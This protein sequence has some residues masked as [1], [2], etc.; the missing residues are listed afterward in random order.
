[1]ETAPT[2]TYQ[3]T[4]SVGIEHLGVNP[5]HPEYSSTE[6]HD[7]HNPIHIMGESKQAMEEWMT[8]IVPKVMPQV[9]TLLQQVTDMKH[10]A[11]HPDGRI[12]DDVMKTELGT[13][14]HQ[15]IA[16]EKQ[17]QKAYDRLRSCKVLIHDVLE[18]NPLYTKYLSSISK[19]PIFGRV[20]TKNSTGT[21]ST[22]EQH[23]VLDQYYQQDFLHQY[24]TAMMEYQTVSDQCQHILLLVSNTRTTLKT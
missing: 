23:K 5:K 19:L 4:T 24:E 20:G 11:D 13:I 16:F 22:T 8:N 6:F 21:T 14:F 7:H 2:A 3:P 18:V 10:T 12:K 17:M 1:M 15:T 9:S